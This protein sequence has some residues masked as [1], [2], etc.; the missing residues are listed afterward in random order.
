MHSE[1][2]D[3]KVLPIRNK[4]F[5]YAYMILNNRQEAEDVVQEAL[6]KLW[7][8]K[9]DLNRISNIEAWS[10]TMVKNLSFDLLRKVKKINKVSLE[11]FIDQKSHES[12]EHSFDRAEDME[13]IRLM[14]NA[15]PE[16][17][18]QLIFLRD[19]EGHSYLEIS[20]MMG[21]DENIV[22]VTLFRARENLRKKI[23]KIENYG[24]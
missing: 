19:V 1:I 21:L 8:K 3:R 18:Q 22:K 2:F 16:R 17:Q 20:H 7:V 14:I 6:I 23:L 12:H 4:L 11:T 5:R 10:M 13:R 9:N 15:L 24:L